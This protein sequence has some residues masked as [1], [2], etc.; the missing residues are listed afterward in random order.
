MSRISVIGAGSWGTAIAGL[1]A[2]AGNDVSLWAHSE[3]VAATIRA[4]HRNPRYLT[5]YVLPDRVD[6]SNSLEESTYGADAILLVVPS[7]HIRP[8]ARLASAHVGDDVPVLV[9]TKGIE[10]DT[11]LLMTEVT[12]EELGHPERLAALSGPNH[13]EEVCLGQLSAAVVASTSNDVGRFFQTLLN[14]PSFRVYRS[15]DVIGV[16]TCGAVKNVIAIACGV[17]A[18]LGAGDNTEALI[19]TRGLAEIGRVVKACGGDPLTC[20]GLAGMGDLIAT[21][22]SEHSRN[23][24]FGEALAAGSDLAD[25][26]GTTHMVVEG[27][28]A[29]RSVAE[30]ARR[31][32]VDVP[33]TEAVCRILYEGISLAEAMDRLM[34]R[35]PDSEFY[36]LMDGR[37]GR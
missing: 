8:V 30:V 22:T 36:G 10:M 5:S 17:A 33:I 2:G 27:A 31:H 26:E 6:S 35:I 21:C 24:R 16:E 23:R 29:A 11:G 3:E 25:F 14:C 28:H 4:D 7:T 19:M 37:E 32:D 1:V 20:M 9:L 13:A 12:A 34:G 15:D 18:G